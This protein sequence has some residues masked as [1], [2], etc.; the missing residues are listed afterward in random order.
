[1]ASSMIRRR[2]SFSR[3][4]RDAYSYLNSDEEDDYHF[5]TSDLEVPRLKQQYAFV[6]PKHGR[7]APFC[8][9]FSIIAVIFLFILAHTLNNDTLYTKLDY[10]KGV[11]KAQMVGALYEAMVIYMFIGT[12]S[13][14]V[15]FARQPLVNISAMMQ[16]ARASRAQ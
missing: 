1:M 14:L 12:I 9:I 7:L 11:N 6:Q 8:F 4:E 5:D 10:N 3:E 2:S 15:V 16:E 13:G